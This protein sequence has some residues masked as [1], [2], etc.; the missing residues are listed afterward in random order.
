MVLTPRVYLLDPKRLKAETIAVAFAKTSRS[1]EAFD[2][3]AASLSDEQSASFGEK[4]IVGYGH[5]SVAEHAVL[6]IALENISRLAVETLESSRLASYTEKSTQYQTWNSSSFYIPPELAGTELLSLFVQTG[7]KLLQTYLEFLPIMRAEIRRQSPPRDG[8]DETAWDRRI[9]SKYV[10]SARFLLPAAC[11]SNVG[12]TINARTLEG[13]I[14]KM[15][16]SPLSEVRSLGVDIKTAALQNAPTLVKYTAPNHFLEIARTTL[17]KISRKLCIE[18]NDGDWLSL[19]N[20][21]GTEEDIL[22]A[23]LFRFGWA[24]YQS[25]AKYVAG[26]SA[27]EKKSLIEDLL[28][29][30]G[31]HDIPLREMEYASAAFEIVMDQGAYYEIKRHRMSTQTPQDLTADLGFAVPRLIE[32]CGLSTAYHET[33]M[34]VSR[35]YKTL[36]DFSPEVAAYIVPNGFNRRVA[37]AMNLREAFH[38]CSLRTSPQTHFSA[39]RVALRVLDEVSCLFPNMA[40][41]IHSPRTETWQSV[42][43]AYFVRTR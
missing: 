32:T 20:H 33:M 12:V 4:W 7:E 28:G 26:L 30:L 11:L 15:L 21:S 19:I 24:D 43:E 31:N 40:S 2:E 17:S 42:E 14:G 41:F 35:A 29:P 36:A 37:I 39:R 18:G 25:C 34:C 9:R 16:A 38:F 5:S 1:P 6:H 3:I 22:A 23:S 8:E 10:D 13:L 27:P